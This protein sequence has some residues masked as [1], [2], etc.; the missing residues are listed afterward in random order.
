MTWRHAAQRVDAGIATMLA[1]VTD[2]SVTSAEARKAVTQLEA[3]VAEMITLVDIE[4]TPTEELR[5]IVTTCEAF[6]A[7]LAEFERRAEAILAILEHQD[8]DGAAVA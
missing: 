6:S 8:G 1:S 4:Q 3:D 2:G 7:R 5:E